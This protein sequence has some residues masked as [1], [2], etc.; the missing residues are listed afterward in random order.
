MIN[1]Q[2]PMKTPYLP[3]LFQSRV[4]AGNSVECCISSL[5]VLEVIKNVGMGYTNAYRLILDATVRIVHL[6]DLFKVTPVKSQQ[7]KRSLMWPLEIKENWLFIQ[8]AFYYSSFCF[9]YKNSTNFE[10]SRSG[11]FIGVQPGVPKYRKPTIS[12]SPSRPKA[13]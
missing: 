7:G 4:F 6:S 8:L 13:W 11:A 1:E 12:S 3:M 9:L 10:K 5:E 2:L